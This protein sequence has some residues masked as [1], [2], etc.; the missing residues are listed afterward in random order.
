M[1]LHVLGICGTF[2]GGL[3]LLARELGHTVTGADENVYPPMS[4][5]LES[6]GIAITQGYDAAQLDDAPDEVVVGNAMTRGNPVVERLLDDKHALLSGPEWLYR[7]VLARRR[8]LAVAGTHGKT[9]T[10]A[11]IAAVLDETGLDPT[12]FVGGR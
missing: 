10:T 7:N 6:H 5:Q 1:R 11:M 4:G 12:A 8:V 3:A 2:M 9:T